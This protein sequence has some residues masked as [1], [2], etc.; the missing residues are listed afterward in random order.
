MSRHQPHHSSRKQLYTEKNTP[1]KQATVSRCIEARLGVNKSKGEIMW[2][3]QC[4]ALVSKR[5]CW[6]GFLATPLAACA[7]S[8]SLSPTAETPHNQRF[9]AHLPIADYG[10][11]FCLAHAKIHG[12]ARAD[13]DRNGIK[14]RH[15][16][17]ALDY[18]LPAWEEISS[19]QAHMRLT[20]RAFY[21]SPAIDADNSLGVSL[22]SRRT[23]SL[24]REKKKK[25][26]TQRKKKKEGGGMSCLRLHQNFCLWC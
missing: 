16:P 22:H 11:L 17:L 12:C 21:L 13:R 7:R 23:G 24:D 9:L 26:K 5:S 19:K 14:R 3:R 4:V 10:N 6:V 20:D 2:W 15:Q 8:F 25:K 18:C 1:N